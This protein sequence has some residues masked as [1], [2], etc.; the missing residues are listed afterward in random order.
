MQPSGLI[1]YAASF[2]ILATSGGILVLSSIFRT[3]TDSVSL[4]PMVVDFNSNG[5]VVVVA[6]LLAIADG[7]GGSAD[8]EGAALTAKEAELYSAV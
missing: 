4:D 8:A 3:S 6:L 2:T 7:E 5:V 1:V